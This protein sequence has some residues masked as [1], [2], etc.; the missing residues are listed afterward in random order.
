MLSGEFERK[1]KRLN[2]NIRVW[3]GD[4]N[5]AAGVYHIDSQGQYNEICGC[6]KNYLPE[7]TEFNEKGG[8]LR[9]GWRRVVRVLIQM[10]LVDRRH[11][12]KVFQTHFPYAVRKP[13]PPAPK[14]VNSAIEKI[15]G[16]LGGKVVYGSGQ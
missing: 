15:A 4:S 7:H 8:I 6:D 1:L 11:A 12:E 3:C 10:K 5:R 16:R 2:R 14:P 13:T 9:G